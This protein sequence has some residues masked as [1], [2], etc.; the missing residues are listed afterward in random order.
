MRDIKLEQM[1]ER[2]EKYL[3]NMEKVF[4]LNR[5]MHPVMGDKIDFDYGRKKDI[6][7]AKGGSGGHKRVHSE[8]IE[9][10]L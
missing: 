7:Q 5:R 9:L 10:P 1:L 8:L 2:F 4:R 3:V 6:M